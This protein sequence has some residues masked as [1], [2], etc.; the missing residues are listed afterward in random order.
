MIHVKAMHG[1]LSPIAALLGACLGACLAGQATAQEQTQPQSLATIQLNAG[2]HNIK[3]QLASTPNQRQMGLMFRR[4]MPANEGMLFVFDSP[5]QQCF[6]MRNTLLPLSIAFLR[7][8]GTVVNIDDM[9]PQTDDSHCSQQ[10]VRFVLEMNVGWFAKR[11]VKAG[12]V[13]QGP[14]FSK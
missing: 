3:A 8:D 7:D 13:I 10:P 1:R 12:S 9:Q 4:S 11:G 6:W 14:P 5:S 2:M